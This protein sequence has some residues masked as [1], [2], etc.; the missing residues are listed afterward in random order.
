MPFTSEQQQR[1]D[2]FFAKKTRKTVG[3]YLGTQREEPG[4][5][6]LKNVLQAGRERIGKIKAIH[7]AEPMAETTFP[8]ELGVGLRTAEEITK[9][10]ADILDIGLSRVFEAVPEPIK[11]SFA[12]DISNIAQTRPVQTLIDDAGVMIDL[13]RDFEKKF[14]EAAENLEAVVNVVG[15][16]AGV[17]E[18]LAVLKSLEKGTVEILKATGRGA[19]R[20]K[21]AVEPAREFAATKA[22]EAVIG[23]RGARERLPVNIAERKA[24]QEIIAGL[25]E[26]AQ[27]ATRSGV[28][29]RDVEIVNQATS[30]ELEMMREMTRRSK[31]FSVDRK[32][33][34][35]MDI[36]GNEFRKRIDTLENERSRI[37]KQLGEFVENLPD[38][39]VV[40]VKGNVL[41]RMQETPGL[42][43]IRLTDDGLL[44]FADTALSGSLTK[45]DRRIIQEAFNDLENRGPQQ[46]HKLRQEIFES[47]GGRKR[48]KVELSETQEKGLDAVRRGIAD[49]LEAL[50]DGY[51]AANVDYREVVEPLKEIRRFFKNVAKADDDILD[52]K[53]ALL[54]RRLTSH[55]QTAPELRQ[56]LAQME[57]LLRVRG[58][59]FG[60]DVETL[61]DFLNALS[62][63]YDITGDTTFAGQVRLGVRDVSRRGLIERGVEAVAREAGVTPSTQQRALEEL[64]DL[65]EEILPKAKGVATPL[66][67]AGKKDDLLEKANE[68]LKGKVG[69]STEDVTERLRASSGLSAKEIVAKHPDIQLKRDVPAKD[70]HGKKVVIPDGE[71]L[72]PYEMKGN[73]VLLQDGET[74]IVSKNQYANIKGQSISGEAKPFAP[75]LEGLE[76]TVK[77]DMELET[78]GKNSYG[79][80]GTEIAIE[81]SDNTYQ[82]F[83]AGSIEGEYKTLAEAKNAAKGIAN[84]NYNQTP[85]TKFSQYQL[86]EGKNYKEILI[87]APEKVKT[88]LQWKENSRGKWAWFQGEKQLSGAFAENTLTNKQTARGTID[89]GTLEKVK[90]GF[91][92]SHWDEPNVIS[93]LRMNERTYK[94]KKVSFMEELQS[95]WA[96]EGRDKGFA[97]TLTE[98]PEDLKVVKQKHSDFYNVV[99]KD[100]D[101][102]SHDY[103]TKELAIKDYL[104]SVN[105]GVPFHPLVKGN[106]WQEPTIKRALKEAVDTNADYFAWINGKQTSARYDLAT[107]IDNK[108]IQWM[109]ADTGSKTGKWIKFRAREGGEY[110]WF[111]DKNGVMDNVAGTYGRGNSN[112]QGK[113][114]DEVLGKGLADKIMEK[115]SGTLSG[116]GLKFGGEWAENL[117]DR[118]VANIAKDLTGAKVVKLDMGLPIEAREN[119]WTMGRDYDK[120]VDSGDS[121]YLG[122]ASRKDLKRGGEIIKSREGSEDN[123]IITDILGDGKFKAISRKKLRGQGRLSDKDIIKWANDN[124]SSKETF[125]ISIKKATQQGIK[126]TPEIKAKI[127]GEAPKF[128]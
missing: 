64:L 38:K 7:V 24:Q 74:Y 111:V 70:I 48:A 67:S 29:V 57:E 23:V 35:P 22:K 77:G 120:Y 13:Y 82:V 17:V 108:G 98:L 76:E 18:G 5:K 112:I 109:K 80:K 81:K 50:S 42:E 68:F 58:F 110:N 37:G 63:Y 12:K 73:K 9:F 43:G 116:E 122:N 44:D 36:V 65:T 126:L 20:A 60:T 6:I 97:K 10:G 56:L 93:H 117:Y 25:P 102:L 78:F 30:Q 62:R 40:G 26:K 55:A 114:L 52:M 106:K 61:Q 87:K 94:G 118:Q 3:D 101:L 27:K 105:E 95:D 47:L 99:N 1:A 15:F 84:E 85:I 54:A 75:E 41:A 34:N 53:A 51:K 16:A 91:K 107:Q 88:D 14:P 86:P 100:G 32:A 125:D 39:P 28:M 127:R 124:P 83:D 4:S 113:K 11:Q 31:Q 19:V 2:E 49:S 46:L 45:S 104:A 8:Q 90:G 79:V 103:L 72:T 128:R 115:E 123:Y 92:S 121:K 59:D 96:R 89:S 21:K 69:L 33:S 71:V 66:K 119:R